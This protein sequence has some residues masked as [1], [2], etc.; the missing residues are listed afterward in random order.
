M[1]PSLFDSSTVPLLEQVVNFAQARHSVLA[2]NIANL[3]TPGYRVRDLSTEEFQNRLK[4]ALEAKRNGAD[5]T[6]SPG[7]LPQDSN[8][9]M[10]A[11]RESMQSILYHDGTDVSVESQVTEISKNQFMHDMAIALMNSQFE[12]L[13]AA[14]SERV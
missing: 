13:Q 7:L 2:G 12:I 3:E 8:D 9:P 1:L 11:V 14:I 6:H 5:E 4:E 10:F